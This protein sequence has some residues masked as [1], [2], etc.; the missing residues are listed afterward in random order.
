MAL[1]ITGKIHR[2]YPPMQ[3][4]DK[5][6][7]REFVIEIAEVINGETYS[8]LVKF[9]CCQNKV[10]ILNAFQLG[11][12]VTVHFNLK[13]QMTLKEGKE[14]FFSNLDCWKVEVPQSQQQ[15]APP[16]QQYPAQGGYQQAPPQG[17]PQQPQQQYAPP[18]QG[19]QAPPQ[20]YQQPAPPPPQ[21]Q[22]PPAPQGYQQYQQPPQGGYQA[23]PGNYPTQ[24][25]PNG[26]G[27]PF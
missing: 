20:Q 27:L 18:A 6:K 25:G 11:Q 13:G 16:Q 2:L 9:Q 23:G 4:N 3:V 14:L 5:F 22:Q 8:Q 7:K 10:D 15:Q 17:Y 12:L 24:P 1:K 26:D 19:Y 21:Y